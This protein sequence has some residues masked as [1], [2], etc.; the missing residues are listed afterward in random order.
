MSEVKISK[1][2]EKLLKLA[3]DIVDKHE[4]DGD[5]S[6]LEDVDI[7]TLKSTKNQARIIYEEA[8]ALRRE[9]EKKTEQYRK[10]LGIHK[11][12][13]SRTPGTALYYVY[14]SRDVLKGIFR[15]VLRKLG[16]WGFVV[17]DPNPATDTENSS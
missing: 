15:N 4:A 8:L 13:R 9:S 12:Q 3:D 6:V 16:D 17:N 5:A 1:N 7:A 10:L 14:Q 11:S 2:P